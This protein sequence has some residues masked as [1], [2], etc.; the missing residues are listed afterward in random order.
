M[1]NY[2]RLFTLGFLLTLIGS[3]MQVMA[4]YPDRPVTIIVP[5]GA[6]GGTDLLARGLAKNLSTKWKQPVVVENKPGAAGIIGVQAMTGRPH[7][8][9]TLMLTTE[10][11]VTAT[12]SLFNTPNYEPLK[13][14]APVAMVAT[15]A[16]AAVVHPSVPV[17]SISELIA[18]MKEYNKD[19][20]KMGFATSPLGSADHM[21][22]EKFQRAAGVEM[23]VIPYKGTAPAIADVAGGHVPLGFFSFAGSLQ[24]INNGNV[25][26]LGITAEERSDLLPGVPTISETIPGYSGLCWFGVWAAAGTPASILEKINS[27]IAQAVT[28]PEMQTLMDS[29]GLL[30]KTMSLSDFS[31]FVQQES[32]STAEFIARAGIKVQ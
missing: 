12:P 8:G 6:G 16:Y 1:I 2:K 25:R 9:Y 17:H 14:L 20:K 24:M 10:S 13:Q 31:T 28:T 27:D 26:V 7:D 18:L 30:A 21:A 23:L 15:Q 5:F 3:P 32:E 29:N 22:G 19:N 4:E 11:T